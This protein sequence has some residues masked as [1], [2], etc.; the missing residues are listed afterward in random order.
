MPGEVEIGWHVKVASQ[1]Y[2]VWK[3]V[4]LDGNY[5]DLKQS[6]QWRDD[7][8]SRAPKS[9]LTRVCGE[10]VHEPGRGAQFHTCGK[11]SKRPNGMCGVHAGAIERAAKKEAE[12]KDD[13]AHQTALIDAQKDELIAMGVEGLVHTNYPTGKWYACH[14]GRV[15]LTMDEIRRLVAAAK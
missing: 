14:T 5:A 7:N 9:R 4:G 1:K 3:V 2:G 12:R 6:V 13:R 11:P 15:V 10:T 8:T